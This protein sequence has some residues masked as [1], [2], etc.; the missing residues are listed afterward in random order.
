MIDAEFRVVRFVADRR[1]FAAVP[2]WSCALELR[3]E[4]GQVSIGLDL[5]WRETQ[6]LEAL[7]A[8]GV[9]RLSEIFGSEK[10]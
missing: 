2:T 6:R 4:R 9:V 8:R 3:S 7:A 1:P 5:P 10:P